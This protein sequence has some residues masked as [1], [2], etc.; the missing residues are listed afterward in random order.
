MFIRGVL[1]V[2]LATEAVSSI[3]LPR[4]LHNRFSSV[5]KKMNKLMKGKRG[6]QRPEAEIRSE[7]SNYTETKCYRYYRLVLNYIFSAI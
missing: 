7:T 1:C 5:K 6:W 2:I 4:K 3:G